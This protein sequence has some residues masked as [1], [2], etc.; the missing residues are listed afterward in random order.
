MNQCSK[1]HI[2]SF[3][4]LLTVIIPQNIDSSHN[5]SSY[6]FRSM[7]SDKNGKV[8]KSYRSTPLSSNDKFGF[9]LLFKRLVSGLSLSL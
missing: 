8:Q 7:Y 2:V 1:L 9:L 6:I 3:M 4:L 5:S